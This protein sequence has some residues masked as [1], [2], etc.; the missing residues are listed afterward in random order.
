M[1][2]IAN[3]PSETCNLAVAKLSGAPALQEGVKYWVVATTDENQA[4]LD[5]TWYGSNNAQ[6]ALNLGY[7]WIQFGFGTPGF[8]VQ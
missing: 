2:G 5:A 6:F 7:S 4:A 8:L 1:S 3:V